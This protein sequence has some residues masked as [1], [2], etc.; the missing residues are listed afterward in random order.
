MSQTTNNNNLGAFALCDIPPET[1]IGIY[2]GYDIGM[3][4][5]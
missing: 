5:E 3:I 2:Y 4:S 1:E